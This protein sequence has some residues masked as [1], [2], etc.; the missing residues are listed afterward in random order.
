MKII[1]WLTLFLTA[2][3]PV[4][5]V[6]KAT[7]ISPSFVPSPIASVLVLG[8]FEIVNIQPLPSPKPSPKPSPVIPLSPLPSPVKSF[9]SGEMDALFE[10]Y[11]HFYGVDLN[12]LRGVAGCESGFNP[13]AVNGPYLGLFQ[14]T[15][16]AWVNTRASMGL[17]SNPD[18]RLNAE[19]SIKTAAF[20]VSRDGFG[21]WP[22]CSR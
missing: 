9:T 20:K 6:I 17:D 2:L 8:E 18:L 19:E 21:A 7:D 16:S 5:P 12:K 10:K 4:K 1:Y 11:A 22:A 13:G 14:F 15:V 3:I